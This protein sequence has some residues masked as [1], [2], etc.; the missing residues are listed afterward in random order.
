MIVLAITLSASRTGILISIIIS[1]T[2]IIKR[3]KINFSNVTLWLK[4]IMMLLVIAIILGFYI[5]KK[6]STK[7]RV[8]I[9]R[10][11]WEMIKEKPWFGHGYKS[12][13]AKYML[14]QADYFEQNKKSRLYLIV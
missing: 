3:Y 13:E 11:T 10:C 14:Y 6:D 4:F 5:F 7:G 9:W 1:V 2:Y 12:F 8:I